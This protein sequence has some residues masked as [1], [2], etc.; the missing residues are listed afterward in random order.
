MTKARQ[1]NSTAR[2][3]LA[4]PSYIRYVGARLFIV[5]SLQMQS[6][7]VGRRGYEITRGPLALGLTG[8]A[9]FLPSILLF[10]VAG[11]AADRWDRRRLV[12][13]CYVVLA[14]SSVALLATELRGLQDVYPIYL[15]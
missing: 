10:L 2:D 14:L 5:L 9:Q 1:K 7:A 6:V 3:V 8:L 11:P 12:L 4:N 13:S 15:V